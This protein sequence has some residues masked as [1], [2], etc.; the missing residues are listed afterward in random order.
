MRW[1]RIGLIYISLGLLSA[2][3]QAEMTPEW[4]KVA[5]SLGVAMAATSAAT[6]VLELPSSCMWCEPDAFDRSASAAL[7]LPDRR[8]VSLASDILVYGI[9][10]AASL[11]FVAY[12]TG[13][14]ETATYRA[15][16]LVDVLLLN[17]AVVEIFKRSFAR[18]R[19]E[20]YWGFPNIDKSD[21]FLS[22]PS[23]HTS[24]AFALVSAVSTMAFL[25][26]ISWAPYVALGGGLA[27][28]TVSYLRVAAGKHWAT[29]I[30]TGI[31]IGS[32]IGIGLPLFLNSQRD[33]TIAPTPTGLQFSMAW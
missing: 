15:L 16:I 12:S 33:A 17:Y 11:G 3:A 25:D 5:G 6:L 4:W 21:E 9:L 14:L 8:S 24:A 26:G 23:G 18:A 27:A 30:I 31:A 28:L 32:V 22:F 10:P 2:P 19:P 13:N 7:I 29:D 20:S 1:F